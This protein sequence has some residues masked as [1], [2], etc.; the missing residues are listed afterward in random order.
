MI[1]I[2]EYARNMIQKQIKDKQE[3]YVNRINKVKSIKDSNKGWLLPS[4]YLNSSKSNLLFENITSAVKLNP[5]NSNEINFNMIKTDAIDYRKLSSSS[6]L[7]QIKKEQITKIATTPS[8]PKSALLSPVLS[9]R[10]FYKDKM[11]RDSASNLETDGRLKKSKLFSQALST[12]PHRAN[13][14]SL[15]NPMSPKSPNK[16]SERAIIERLALALSTYRDLKSPS[17]DRI[18]YEKGCRSPSDSFRY[19]YTNVTDENMPRETT[20]SREFSTLNFPIKY[21]NPP[22][23]YNLKIISAISTPTKEN[24]L[25]KPFHSSGSADIKPSTIRPFRNSLLKKK[26]KHQN[27]TNLG[28]NNKNYESEIKIPLIISSNP[29][30]RQSSDK[31]PNPIKNNTRIKKNIFSTTYYNEFIGN[32]IENENTVIIRENHDIFR[33]NN[34][35]SPPKTSKAI[36]RNSP[37]S[38]RVNVDFF[39]KFPFFNPRSQNILVPKST[40]SLG[41]LDKLIQINPKSKTNI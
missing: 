23:D 27:D 37:N 38:K 4:K 6:R 19:F 1:S 2:D 29:W 15:K 16:L 11:V 14:K 21:S 28:G 30:L 32:D 24:Y 22:E 5:Q 17:K 26:I 7:I 35:K 40:E 9:N 36:G 33:P 18:N 10:N 41:S 31:K 13:E 39:D 12:L 3:L 34:S 8:S 20:I 25:K